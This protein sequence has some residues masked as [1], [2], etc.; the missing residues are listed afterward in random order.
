MNAAGFCSGSTVDLMPTA[1]EFSI[2]TPVYN[3]GVYLFRTIRSVLR[4]T[5]SDFELILVD[6]GSTDDA[7]EK[8]KDFCDSRVRI[9]RQSNHGASHACNTGLAAARGLNVA[10][11]DQDDLWAPEMLACHRDS[12]SANDD[13][14]LTF[15]WSCYIGESDEELG[16]PIRRWHGRI[17]FDQLFIT[18]VI[19]NTSSVAI[20]RSAM[21][22]AGGFDVRLRY[23]YDLDLFLRVLRL[24]PANALAIPKVLAF[25]RRHA[26]QMSRNWRGLQKDWQALVQKH[27]MLA[28][29]TVARLEPRANLNM[30]RYFAYLAYESREFASGCRLLAEG[31][32]FH[33]P[34]FVIDP[35]NWKMVGACVA[36]GLL[37]AGIHRRLE[38]LAGISARTPGA[39]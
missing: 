8:V 13:I 34:A 19:G 6:D 12:L 31:F 25:Y 33:P 37:P 10:L 7:L 22:R 26:D 39:G 24:R 1:P 21:E 18:N 32:R 5:C 36:G 3:G 14:D 16:L 35:R 27:R 11:I 28:P 9:L 30:Y 20:R 17:A 4:Q 38:N 15:T 2:I 29:E 23:T